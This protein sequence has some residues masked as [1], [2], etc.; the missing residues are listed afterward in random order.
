M[1]LRTALRSLS[2]TALVASLVPL[3]CASKSKETPAE[4]PAPG[5]EDPAAAAVRDAD[6]ATVTALK[7]AIAGPQRSAE[8]RA[9]DQYRHPL[10][11][12]LFFGLKKDMTVVELWPGGGGWFTEILA[13]TLRDSGKLITTNF[14][15]GGPADAY[16]TRS[17]NK[18]KEKLAGAPEVYDK[19]EVVT[20]TDP[21]TLVLAPEGS[22]DL[23]VTF[24]N[25]HNWVE[26]NIDGAIYGAAFKALKSGGVLGVEAHRGKPGPVDDPKKTAE[27]GY[28]PEDWVVA[29][30]ESYGF[31]LQ[32]RSEINANPKDTKDYEKGVWTLPPSLELGD[33]DR[34]KYTAIGESDRMTLKFV[35]P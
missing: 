20:V 31:K 13:P 10:E 23:V 32:A 21:T 26:D 16:Q 18:F 12:L 3:G 34:D 22:V 8:N 19:V 14:D 2:L 30:I 17:G 35:K 7:A 4:S 27:T 5:G 29:R 33:K 24:R 28:L 15:T 6:P 25:T 11:T 1:L 9:R